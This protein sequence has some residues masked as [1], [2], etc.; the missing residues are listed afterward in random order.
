MKKIKTLVKEYNL[1]EET[2]YFDMIAESIVN[3][4]REQAKNQF[5]AMDK[6]SRKE[7]VNITHGCW[8]DGYEWCDEFFINLI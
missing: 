2:E 7:F 1:T 4:Q 6:T 5:L 8:S 3:G